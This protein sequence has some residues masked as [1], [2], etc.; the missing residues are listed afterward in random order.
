M[1]PILFET[2]RQ[3][4]LF[5]HWSHS[6]TVSRHS[7]DGQKQAGVTNFDFEPGQ[8]D[9]LELAASRTEGANY[10]SLFVGSIYTYRSNPSI[11]VL[12]RNIFV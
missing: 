11:T 7:D 6:S 9:V 10:E 1:A 8:L 3:P 12:K 5:F 2:L 4:R